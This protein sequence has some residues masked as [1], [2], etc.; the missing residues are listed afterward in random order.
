MSAIVIPLL[1]S[2]VK[3]GDPYAEF[4]AMRRLMLAAFIALDVSELEARLIA[5]ETH[6]AMRSVACVGD[7]A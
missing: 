1:R 2:A 3:E 4:H 5:D 7:G 6:R